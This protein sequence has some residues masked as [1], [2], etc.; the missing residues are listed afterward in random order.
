MCGRY[1]LTYENLDE[2]VAM[3]SA[4]LDPAAAELYRPRFNI[5]PTNAVVI[6]R[7][8]PAPSSPRPALVPAEWGLR[9]DRRLIINL[10]S[11]SAATRFPT[12][13]RDGRCVVPADGFY[14]WTGER[15]ER[16]PLWFHAGGAPLFMAGLCEDRPGGAPAFAVLTTASRPPVAAVHD[17]M[18]VLLSRESARSFLLGEPPRVIHPDAIPLVARPVSPRVNTVAHDDPACLEGLEASH[19][20]APAATQL[21]LFR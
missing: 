20:P 4:V 21:E 12:A 15:S 2:I 1:T 3:L 14:E 6:A 16:R 19:A 7:S 18:P 8:G 9:R 5:A 11:E 13:Y 17:R 10:R